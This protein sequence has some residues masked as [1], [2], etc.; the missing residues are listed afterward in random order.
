MKT[1][2]IKRAQAIAADYHGGQWSGLY[3]FVSTGKV[4]EQAINEVTREME[5]G[6]IEVGKCG[7]WFFVYQYKAKQRKELALLRRFLVINNT[8]R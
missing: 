6:D 7:G 1:I 3:T 4:G 2:S 5:A 8:R